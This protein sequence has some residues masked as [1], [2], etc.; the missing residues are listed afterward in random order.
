MYQILLRKLGAAQ[1]KVGL[2]RLQRKSYRLNLT[3]LMVPEKIK[4]F[5]KW[6]RRSSLGF[7]LV[8]LR[9]SRC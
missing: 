7:V 6:S 9:E 8:I 1:V 2:G 3:N 5:T 4:V